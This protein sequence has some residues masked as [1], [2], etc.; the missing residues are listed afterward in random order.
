MNQRE[1]QLIA[2]YAM[3]RDKEMEIQSEINSKK[4]KIDQEIHRIEAYNNIFIQKEKDEHMDIRMTENN[5]QSLYRTAPILEPSFVN[6]NV[7]R[8][9]TSL[10]ILNNL[11]AESKFL[12]VKLVATQP[13]LSEISLLNLHSL[14]G[15]ICVGSNGLIRIYDLKSGSVRFSWDVSINSYQNHIL[16]IHQINK[17]RILIGSE[18]GFVRIIDTYSK[19][20][21]FEFLASSSPIVSVYFSQ[22]QILYTISQNGEISCWRGPSSCIQNTSLVDLNTTKVVKIQEITEKVKKEVSVFAILTF[23][24]NKQTK[25]NIKTNEFLECENFHQ[26]SEQESE[27]DEENVEK[28]DENC[29]KTENEKLT[30]DFLFDFDSSKIEIRT[31]SEDIETFSFDPGIEN[32]TNIDFYKSYFC[33]SVEKRM[34]VYS[35]SQKAVK[36]TNLDANLQDSKSDELFPSVQVQF[37]PMPDDPSSMRPP[38]ENPFT[39]NPLSFPDIDQILIGNVD[40]SG[41]RDMPA[42]GQAPTP[43]Y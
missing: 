32:F 40:K 16:S 30:N 35:V 14:P 41:I 28:N 26:E 21:E 31:K 17:N 1:K 34:Y 25:W 5:S 15:S 37:D 33:F 10:Q 42:P 22:N 43:L 36:T 4:E 38:N 9:P 7:N 39:Q 6:E 8:I 19:T 24:D 18:D 23:S 12:T 20:V 13:F 29:E 11:V 3:L 27:N 2:T